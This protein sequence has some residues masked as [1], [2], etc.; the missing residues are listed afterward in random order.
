MAQT[1]SRWA[2]ARPFSSVST[3]SK[4][5]PKVSE[6]ESTAMLGTSLKGLLAARKKPTA[7]KQATLKGMLP[8]KPKAAAAAVVAIAEPE[9]DLAD[10]A[11][12]PEAAGSDD[13]MGSEDVSCGEARTVGRLMNASWQWPESGAED[14][15]KAVD[16]ETLPAEPSGVS[17]LAKFRA[18]E[19]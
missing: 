16:K 2:R 6:A 8:V 5:M 9:D 11:A 12:S 7:S 15:V 19:V 18:V 3:I 13:E 4:A 17:K 14:D 1:A 10:G